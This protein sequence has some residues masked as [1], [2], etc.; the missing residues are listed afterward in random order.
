MKKMLLVSMFQNVYPFVKE[1]EPA[2]SGQTITY[3]PTASKVEK[4]GFFVRLGKRKL[5][6]LGL[7]IE[8]L[9]I[10]TASYET[11]KSTLERNDCIYIAGGNTFFLL[12]EMKR[13]GA[14]KLIIEA[15]NGGKLYIGESA[16]AI[17]VA[18]DIE[19]SSPMDDKQKAPQLQNYSGLQLVDFYVVPHQGHWQFK[20]TVATIS[21]NYSGKLDLRI[22]NDHQAV[23]VEGEKVRLLEK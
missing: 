20:E 16:G 5:R 12:Q 14:D 19:Y 22:I 4:L 3:I 15:V 7:A 13:T 10:S 2:I 6:K 1:I 9:D 23:F 17:I 18:P 11:I 8:E 21:E